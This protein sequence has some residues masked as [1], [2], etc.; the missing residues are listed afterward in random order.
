MYFGYLEGA[1]ATVSQSGI[2]MSFS[3]SKTNA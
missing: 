1:R 3:F 2:A